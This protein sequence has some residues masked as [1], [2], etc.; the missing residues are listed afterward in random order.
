MS[1]ILLGSTG[2]I[3]SNTLKVAKEF[4]IPIEVLGAGRNIALLNQQIKAFSPKAVIIQNAN[5]KDQLKS[6][7]ARIYIGENG[8]KEAIFNSDSKILL[9]AISGGNGLKASIF[10]QQANKTI[11]LANKESLVSAG[12]LFDTTKII[13]V[14][15][16]HF[17]LW[18]LLRNQNIEHISSLIITASG[19]AFRD[20]PLEDIANKTKKDALKHPNWNMGDKITVDSASM[21]N[22]L[23]ELLEAHWLFNSKNPHLKL[24]AIIERSSNVHALIGHTDGS[25]S[26]HLSYPDMRLAIAYALDLIKAEQISLIPPL[27]LKN[28]FKIKFEEIDY[29]RYPVWSLKSNLLRNPK[30]GVILN[31]ANEILTDAFL[32]NRIPFGH[33]ATEIIESIQAYETKCLAIQ[34]FEDVLNLD[35]EIKAYIKQKLA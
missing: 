11:A 30:L 5:D 15:S 9:N 20:M 3:G 29:K 27:D 1:L 16:E 21:I 2:S 6:N 32:N 26:A 34:N 25:F 10:A 31:A 22:K 24:D 28:L 23:F 35:L 7:G 33:I 14:D 17:S 4:G 19:G 12:W 18:Y 8:L 13:P